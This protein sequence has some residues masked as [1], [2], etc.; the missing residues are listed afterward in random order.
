MS[1]RLRILHGAEEWHVE[2]SAD[3]IVTIGER[4]Y[5][6]TPAGDGRY[7][8]VDAEGA[9]TIVAV[10]GAAPTLWASAEGRAHPL[11]ADTSP[12]RSRAA[13]P[14]ASG[15]L[16]A[17]MPATV[18]KVVVAVGDRVA[19]GDPVVVLEAMK[20]ELTIRAP[21]DGVVTAI[22]CSTGELVA[23]GRPLVELG[24]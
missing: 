17:P 19:T 12:T 7:R 23:P 16:S 3:G 13:R 4:R 5:H 8:V 6:V 22:A 15:D 10:A 14:S 9:S 21:R 24:A 2:A 1:R 18:V 20:M 11:T